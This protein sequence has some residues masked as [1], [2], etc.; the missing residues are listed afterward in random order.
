MYRSKQTK[1]H[2]VSKFVILSMP[3]EAEEKA[4]QFLSNNS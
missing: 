1:Q 2:D 3:H 4:Y